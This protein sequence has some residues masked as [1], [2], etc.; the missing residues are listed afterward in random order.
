MLV[1]KKEENDADELVVVFHY[2]QLELEEGVT[3]D[4]DEALKF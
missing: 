2:F 3:D 4:V 1:L